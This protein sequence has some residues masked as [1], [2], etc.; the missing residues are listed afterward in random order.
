M[1]FPFLVINQHNTIFVEPLSN[2]EDS[3]YNDYTC[4]LLSL[5]LMVLYNYYFQHHSFKT[6]KEFWL[7]E[8]Y[9]RI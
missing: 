9:L 5:S 6:S 1:L 8:Y 7:L 3:L 2:L 4:S